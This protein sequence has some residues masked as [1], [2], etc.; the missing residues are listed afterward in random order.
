[1]LF[2][3]VW[4]YN[5]VWSRVLWYLQCCSFCSLLPF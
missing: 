5:I 3:L 4:I 1:M 2:L